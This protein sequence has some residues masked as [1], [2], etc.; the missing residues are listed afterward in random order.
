MRVGLWLLTGLALLLGLAHL[1]LSALAWRGGSAEILW[2]AGSGLAIVA[3]ALLN[4]AMLRATA[5]DRVQ[6]AC[7]LT[8]NL[9]TA[10]FFALAWSVVP[11][12][13]VIVGAAVFALLCI[14]PA[15]APGA[16]RSAA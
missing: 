1:G 8:A 16:A 10:A 13:Q 14:G 3:A 9:A 4:L 2:F 11:E 15:H 7:W 12:P 5:A 6:R